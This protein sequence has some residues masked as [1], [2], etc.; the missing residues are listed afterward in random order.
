MS[1]QMRPV[2]IG[3]T[4]G[5][6]SGKSFVASELARHGGEVIDADQLGHEV[7]RMPEVVEAARQRWGDKIIAA[8]GQIDR[9]R[10]A[11]I[12]FGE[13]AQSGEELAY[14]EELTHPRI[15]E[16]MEKQVTELSQRP[17]VAAILID[18]PLLI[19]AGWNGFCD[20]IVYVEA[21][22][23]IRRSRSQARGWNGEDFDRREARQESLEV[24]RELADVVIDNSSSRE[25]VRDEIDRAWHSLVRPARSR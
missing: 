19:E 18:A 7:L 21:P 23:A 9:K 5:I 17:G 16:R 10:L 25:S 12:V 1:Q 14:L 11:E 13:S 22:R 6:A 20:K 3:I 2:V 8:D 4:G 15:R 24:K